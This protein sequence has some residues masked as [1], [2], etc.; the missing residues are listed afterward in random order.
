M[1]KKINIAKTID[2][3]K[4]LCISPDMDTLRCLELMAKGQILEVICDHPLALQR[5]PRNLIRKGHKLLSIERVE[6]PTHRMFIEAFS[7]A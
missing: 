4:L 3:R 5:L 2:V 6:G 7:L 1:K